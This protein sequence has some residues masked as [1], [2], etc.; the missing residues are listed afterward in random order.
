MCWIEKKTITDKNIVI[1]ISIIIWSLQYII[2]TLIR[3]Y[4]SG[5]AIKCLVIPN[6]RGFRLFYLFVY[7]FFNLHFDKSLSS[8]TC[9]QLRT[10]IARFP[11][12]TIAS[13]KWCRHRFDSSALRAVEVCFT[14]SGCKNCNRLSSYMVVHYSLACV[15][16][17]SLVY[18]SEKCHVSGN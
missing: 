13:R 11:Y 14:W 18:F 6:D 15:P 16:D 8:N 2:C 1:I 9:A 10:A 7:F 12:S 17:T 4:P 3:P 5:V